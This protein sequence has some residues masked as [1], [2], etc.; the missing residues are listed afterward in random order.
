MAHLR[1]G[2]AGKD[3]QLDAREGEGMEFGEHR[4]A[5][6]RCRQLPH[7]Q[8]SV[9]SSQ[10]SCTV[11]AQNQDSCLYMGHSL[12]L[13]LSSDLRFSILFSA[14]SALSL[15]TPCPLPSSRDLSLG[16][17]LMIPTPSF[18]SLRPDLGCQGC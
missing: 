10:C 8:F 15:D 11:L 17:V 5:P 7:G 9:L 2:N 16:R 14:L 12:S 13:V 4:A 18:P 3:M 6:P 1:A